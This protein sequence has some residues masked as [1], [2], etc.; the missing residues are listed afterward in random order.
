MEYGRIF[1]VGVRRER[2]VLAKS[3]I[4]KICSE[5]IVA[6]WNELPVSFPQFLEEVSEAQKGKNEAVIEE[7]M[8]RWQEKGK[9]FPKKQEEQL[10]WKQE[11][12]EMTEEFLEKEEILCIRQYMS[13]ETLAEFKEETKR[14]VRQTRSFDP[15]LSAENIWQAL[16]NYFIY[17]LITDLQ[18]Q[19]QEC[20]E[21]AFAYSLLYPYTDNF[22]DEKGHTKQQKEE[23]NR[24]IA[25]VLQG[26]S[27]IPEKGLPT[28]EMQETLEKGL[29][30]MEIQETLEKELPTM[31]IQ[32]KTRQLLERLTGSYQGEKKQEIRNLLL[33]MLEAQDRSIRQQTG[34]AEL[35]KEEILDISAYK[36]SLSVLI[37]YFFTVEEL[38]KEEVRF[39]MKFGFFLQLAD[40]LQDRK[41]DQKSGSK[42][43]MVHA[44]QKG[45]LAEHVNRLLHYAHRIFAEFTPANNRLKSFMEK[46]CYSLVLGAAMENP[47]C[48]SRE[49]R[50]QME[51]FFPVH[52]EFLQ[53]LSQRQKKVY[54]KS[55]WYSDQLLKKYGD[56]LLS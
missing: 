35:T 28:M 4:R 31:G 11:M 29:P 40:D 47:E 33:M 41:E 36:G 38:R 32:E 20:K 1:S 43:L 21:A 24:M 46:N 55:D 22:I 30:T 9:E 25:D 10:A 14:F 53:K 52:M 26:K 13:Q 42:T 6:L 8:V 51:R 34:K 49:E 2:D 17:A 3:E 44:A 50:E 37:D 27:Q 23:Y 19:K 45:E 5:E 56:L 7:M 12:E 15:E 39:Y 16:R 54:G 18:G 48:F